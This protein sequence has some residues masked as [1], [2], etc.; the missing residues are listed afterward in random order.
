MLRAFLTNQAGV[1]PGMISMKYAQRIGAAAC[2]AAIL[3][4]T[5]SGLAQEVPAQHHGIVASNIDKSVAPGD[6]FY[7]FANGEYLKKTEIPPD[8][9]TVG[10]FSTLNDLANKRTAGLVEEVSKSNAAA[11]SNQ[12]KIADLYNSYMNEAG[13]EAKGLS[14]LQPHL[15]A[16]ADI[17]DKKQLARAFGEGLRSDVD[18]LNNTNYHTANLFGFWL[19]PGFSDSEHYTAYLLQG[20]IGLPDREYY[21]S[22]SPRMKELR[23][24]YVAHVA[25]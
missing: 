3:L 6:D 24:K 25:A 23:T 8:R 22:E 5:F 21:L 13:I 16:I 15:K 11:G 18:P 9:T 19:A 2:A 4:T 7:L 17:K 20:G 1:L 12:R 14:P 10:A